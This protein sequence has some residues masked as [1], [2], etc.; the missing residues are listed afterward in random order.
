MRKWE[1]LTKDEQ[2]II[3]TMKMQGISP[4]EL[5]ERMRSSGRMSPE[6]IEGLRKALDDV[7]EFLV[8]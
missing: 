1:D 2:E 5:I 4:D 7:R 8:H 6:A 3:T